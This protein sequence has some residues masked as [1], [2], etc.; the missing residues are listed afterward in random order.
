M[1]DGEETRPRRAQASDK[2]ETDE[3]D[4]TAAASPGSPRRNSP[5]EPAL[6]PEPDGGEPGSNPFARPGSDSA[7]VPTPESPTHGGDSLEATPIPA[8]VLP[9]SVFQGP[10][11]RRSAHSSTSPVESDSASQQWQW[12]AAHRNRLL[13]WAAGGLAIA[14]ALAL[15]SF[16]IA[17]SI[18]DAGPGTV[19]PSASATATPSPSASAP[20]ITDADL[21]EPADL[22]AISTVSSWSE[23]STTDSVADHQSFATCLS[24]VSVDV[25]PVQSFQRSLATGGD[26]KL[27]TLHQIDAYADEDAATSVMDARTTALS[28]CAAVLVQARIVG[29]SNV[30]GLADRTFQIDLVADDETPDYR[31]LLLTQEGRTLQL[32]EVRR[33][34]DAVPAED[35]ATALTRPQQ[36]INEAAGADEQVDPVVTPGIVPAV[37]PYGWLIASDLPRVRAGAGLWSASEPQALTTFGTGC[38]NM[39]LSSEAGPTQRQVARYQIAQDD[40]TPALFG[41]DQAVFTF[42]NNEAAA[43]FVT[44]LGGN[45][46][47]CKARVPGS[48]VSEADAV[49]SV[50]VDG[51]KG[52]S[53]IFTITRQQSNDTRSAWQA[54]ITVVGERV[55]YTLVSVEGGYQFKAAQLSTLAERIGVR[56]TQSE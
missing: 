9:S 29:A 36:A 21:V 30:T 8:P 48:D 20:P 23:V 53:R 46:A 55:S 35:V 56:L 25:N 5:D 19:S 26:D 6:D 13:I 40:E 1:S 28:N 14:L 51:Q 42:E 22:A 2:P 41:L 37:E 16:F 54:I 43:T 7:R 47:N 44:K 17:R 52:S 39:T 38:E 15:I 32:L 27:A 31:T 24:T 10:A 50:G 12:V 11:P 18:R 49:A 34:D 4:D 33:L 3:I 45:L